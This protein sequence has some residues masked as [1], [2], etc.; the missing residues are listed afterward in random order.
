[1]T[2]DYIDPMCSFSLSSIH[3]SMHAL[4]PYISPILRILVYTWLVM[5]SHVIMS[6]VQ[7]FPSFVML[8]LANVFVSDGLP[9]VEM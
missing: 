5:L 8:S 3:I 1:V 6:V 9:C 4:I 2:L 7:A